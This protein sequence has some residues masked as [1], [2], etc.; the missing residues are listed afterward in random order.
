MLLHQPKVK[1][2]WKNQLLMHLQR[3]LKKKLLLEEKNLF[4]KK[5][6]SKPKL[7]PSKKINLKL[8]IQSQLRKKTNSIFV[9]L[10]QRKVERLHSLTILL[11]NI[12]EAL[13]SWINFAN[14]AWTEDLNS[15]TL[16][17][18]SLRKRKQNLLKQLLHMRL[19][20]RKRRRDK[21]HHHHQTQR[22]I[23]NFLWTSLRKCLKKDSIKRTVTPVQSSIILRVNTGKILKLLL[24]LSV[25]QFLN[26]VF[27]L[28]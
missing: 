2:Q 6:S 27:R 3:K 19:R 20:Q 7:L 10:V 25:R 22:T 17:T 5:K 9:L 11:K 14:G 12:K 18:N 23:N 28:C 24:S 8:N 1:L 13:L 15:L 21:S 16:L 26:K 4:S